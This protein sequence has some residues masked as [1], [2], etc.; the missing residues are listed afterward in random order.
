M[1]FKVIGIGEVLWDLLPSGPQLGGAPVN[2]A[3]HA[4]QFGAEAGVITRVGYDAPGRE[5]LRRLK[6]MGLKNDTVQVDLK[7]PTGAATV[8]LEQGGSPHFSINPDVAWDNLNFTEEALEACR[9]ASA[10]CFGTLAQRNPAASAAIRQMVSAAP[11]LSLRVFDINLRE[12]FYTQTLIEQSME[13]A[14]VVKL[15]EHEL[16]VLAKMFDLTGSPN[17]KLE[18]LARRFDLQL[19]ALTRG[20]T[21]SLLYQTGRW[22]D[23]PGGLVKVVDTVGAGDS[24]TAALVMGLLHGL[25]LEAMHQIAADTAAY[26]CSRPGA[27]PV[28][29]EHVRSAF[30]SHCTSR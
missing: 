18:Q 2:F 23:L 24:F 16:N 17:E 27:T 11:F 7:L 20:E 8:V 29:P 10:L 12:P 30:A 22:S 28:L 13:L 5:I 26:V 21:G 9:Q 19:V 15:N 6:D 3:C 1:S 25:G 14:N 4:G